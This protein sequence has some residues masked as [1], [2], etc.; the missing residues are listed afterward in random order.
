MKE[1]SKEEYQRFFDKKLKKYGVDSPEDLS[2]DEKK[3]FYNEIDKEWK[4]DD[5]EDGKEEAVKEYITRDGN[6]RRCS[7][8]DG[9]RRS[10][11]VSKA[12]EAE[13]CD[14]EEEKEMEEAKG[15]SSKQVEGACKKVGMSPA[16]VGDFFAA[17][18]GK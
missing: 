12:L 8:G 7:G 1:G 18:D 6:R 5:E 14:D 9:R 3:K 11:K 4:S 16:E 13:A 10:V 15:Y 17:L 2:D